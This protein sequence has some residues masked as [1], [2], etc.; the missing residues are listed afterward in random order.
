MTFKELIAEIA[1]KIRAKDG[2]T[3]KISPW[4]YPA[5]IEAIPTGGGGGQE[6]EIIEIPVKEKEKKSIWEG[7]NIFWSRTKKK[8]EQ[9][10]AKTG[11]MLDDLRNEEV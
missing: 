9:A 4:D 8:A 7:L 10:A 3:G 5:R 1:E 2:T 11:E 6:E